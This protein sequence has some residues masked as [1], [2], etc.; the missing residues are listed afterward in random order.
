[1]GLL[2]ERRGGNNSPDRVG[3]G[4][5][6]S[7]LITSAPH[8]RTAHPHVAGSGLPPPGGEGA[9]CWKPARESSRWE[10]R[11]SVH[12]NGRREPRES[13]LR[14]PASATPDGR[15]NTSPCPACESIAV[16]CTRARQSIGPCQPCGPAGTPC[17][18]NCRGKG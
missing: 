13:S 7:H 12:Q 3:S 14:E 15:V 16:G 8:G 9:R 17:L 6:G 2:S 5:T 10:A 18:C 1:M 4:L 11:A